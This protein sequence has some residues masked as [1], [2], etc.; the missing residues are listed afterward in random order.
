MSWKGCCAMDFL[1][2]GQLA[3]QCFSS[4]SVKWGLEHLPLVQMPS[5]ADYEAFGYCS[6]KCWV[7]LSCPGYTASN[8]KGGGLVSP[9]ME[10]AQ[11]LVLQKNSLHI[12][13]VPDRAL[14]RTFGHYCNIINFHT[15]G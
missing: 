1:W 7:S 13:L 11:E 10:F 2:A 4:S 8:L 6:K 12:C 5:H 14:F 3:S 15:G 9:P